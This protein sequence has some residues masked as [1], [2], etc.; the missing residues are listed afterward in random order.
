MY[1]F[2]VRSLR[3]DFL[4]VPEER[5]LVCCRGG[6]PGETFHI[7]NVQSVIPQTGKDV[8][9]GFIGYL[10]LKLQRKQL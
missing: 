9:H 7:H 3:T 8:R 5:R 6:Y 4:N 1:I 10:K 2:A